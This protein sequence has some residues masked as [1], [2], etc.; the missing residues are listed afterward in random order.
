M[1]GFLNKMIEIAGKYNIAKV[2]TNFFDDY[3]RE[4][5][6][7]KKEIESNQIFNNFAHTETESSYLLGIFLYN[8]VGFLLPFGNPIQDRH[9]QLKS[10]GMGCL[11]RFHI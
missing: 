5:I 1:E 10:G 4:Q 7:Y 11:Y 8:P 2:F 3:S 6:D 9:N